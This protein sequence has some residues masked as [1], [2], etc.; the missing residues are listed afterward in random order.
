MRSDSGSG[1]S[2]SSMRPARPSKDEDLGAAGCIGK[3]GVCASTWSALQSARKTPRYVIGLSPKGSHAPPPLNRES[4]RSRSRARPAR[5]GRA[6][7]V[8][9]RDARP[10]LVVARRSI[11]S[12]LS[13]ALSRLRS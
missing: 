1:R 7:A 11:R 13:T 12:S 6:D 8:A 3:P 4:S 10:Q 2:D 5:L 9:G